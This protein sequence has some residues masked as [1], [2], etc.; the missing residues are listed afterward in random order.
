[1]K[2]SNG[3]SAELVVEDGTG[4]IGVR[5]WTEKISYTPR[6]SEWICFFGTLKVFQGNRFVSANFVRIID[7][8]D[9]ICHHFLQCMLAQSGNGIQSFPVPQPPMKKETYANGVQ[10]AI[11]SLLSASKEPQGLHKQHIVRSLHGKF[12]EKDVMSTIGWMMEEG[13]LYTTI[14]E[15]H[16]KK[17]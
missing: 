15:D 12:S 8:H 6:E 10:S 1:M 4:T 9:Q 17:C 13:Y 11:V 5:F 2:E 14:D 3:A 7:D 16:V